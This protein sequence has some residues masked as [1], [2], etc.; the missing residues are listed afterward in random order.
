M[1]FVTLAIAFFLGSA[2]NAAPIPCPGGPPPAFTVDTFPTSGPSSFSFSCAGLTF[3]QFEIIPASGN[4]TTAQLDLTAA[5]NDSGDVILTFNPNLV[6][7]S[8]T[9]FVDLYMYYKVTGLTNAIDLSVSG[10]NAAV[11]ETAC[12]TAIDRVNGNICTSG[13]MAQLAVV[14]NF[15]GYARKDVTFPNGA[16]TNPVYIFKDIS[17][18]PGGALSSFSQSHHGAVPEPGTWALVV[19]GLAA[20][21]IRRFKKQA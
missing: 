15:S 5:Y 2:V 16:Y 9:A 1:L 11:T 4:L 20:V 12:S 8:T 10:Q 7:S 3:S 14:T 13:L 6:N 21:G 19:A 17:V 18:G